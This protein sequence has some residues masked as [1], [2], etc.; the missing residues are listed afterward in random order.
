VIQLSPP[1][2]ETAYIDRAL[3][4]GTEYP[5]IHEPE[6]EGGSEDREEFAEILAGLLHKTG[7]AEAES[8][9]SEDTAGF[10][11]SPFEGVEAFTEALPTALQKHPSQ[12]ETADAEMTKAGFGASENELFGP[13]LADD[14]QNILLAVDRLLNRTVEEN[15]ETVDNAAARDLP[16]EMGSATGFAA[17]V[18][19]TDV[20]DAAEA[21]DFIKTGEQVI[22][23]HLAESQNID[24]EKSKGKIRSGEAV[25]QA[26]QQNTATAAYSEAA[27]RVSLKK[28][29]EKE[30]QTRL[31][32]ARERRRSASIEVRDFRSAN[33]QAAESNLKASTQFRV[34][35]ETRVPTDTGPREI[36]L[37]L[38]LPNQGQN[39]PAATT[40]WEAKAG[41]AFTDLLARE[42][43]QNFNNDI[44]R[45][46]S[47]ALRDEGAGTIRIALKPE[48]LGN[49]KIHL[50]MAENKIT[51]LIVV[52]SEEALR[53]FER[54]IRSLEQAFKDSGFEGANL[55][56][57]LTGD[58]GANQQ[59]QETEASQ[60]LSGQHVAS[61]YDASIERAETPVI[62]DL[63][64]RGTALINVFA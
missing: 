10:G 45:H 39:S 28:P 43:H 14:G 21:G 26:A 60:F 6:N 37:E 19:Q 59:W 53:A 34:N 41:Q 29:V 11:V 22:P 50:E 8:A 42:L 35:A 4:S 17:A 51:G 9:A 5:Q 40:T 18:D 27:E 20:I 24:K 25:A 63:Y 30:G 33:A 47:M 49:V 44:V 3:L 52:E 38:R 58:G 46:A 57:S 62:V 32:A 64:Q 2:V 36:T 15:P 7:S 16:A 56:M 61:R 55:E 23:Q 12:P 13:E 54:E 1:V 31:E 48:T